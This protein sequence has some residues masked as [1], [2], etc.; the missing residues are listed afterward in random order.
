[1]YPLHKT[2]G[3]L[4]LRS[5]K[6][7]LG[8]RL[9]V[10]AFLLSSIALP[11]QGGGNIVDPIRFQAKEFRFIGTLRGGRASAVT[12]VLGEP[13]RYFMG[14]S[15]GGVWETKDAGTTWS[16]VSDGFFAAS[17]IGAIA[18]APSDASIIYVGTG[19]SCIRG[20]VQTGVG[21]YKSSDGGTT[22]SH[23]GLPDSRHIARVRIHPENPDIVYA[24]VLGNVFGPSEDRG[25]YRSTDGGKNWTRSLFV[26]NRAG[27]VDLAMDPGDPDT[28]YAA[29]YQVSRSPWSLISGGEDSGLYKSVDGGEN[30]KELTNG[31]PQGIKG[32][33]G[34]SVSPVDSNK[35]YVN[36][37]A[38]G[39][40]GLY[41][42]DSA[43]ETFEYV[44]DDGRLITRPFYYTHV[45]ASPHGRESVYVLNLD[46]LKSEDGGETYEVINKEIH[47]DFHDLWINPTD[48]DIMITGTDGGAAITLNGGISWSSQL[49]QPTG[50]IYRM[51]TDNRYPYRVYGT[52]QDDWTVSVPSMS[53]GKRVVEDVFS[54]G[55]GEHGHI[56]VHPENPDIVYAGNYEGIITRYDHGTG[57]MRNIE[58][59]P[60]LAEGVPAIELRYRFQMNAPIRI[61][62]HGP[63]VVYQVSQ[64]VHR[65]LDEGQSWEVISPDLTRNDESKQGFSGGPITRDH[66]GVETY[67]TIFAFEESYQHAGVF[68]V[69]TDDGLIHLSRDN[70]ATWENITPPDMPEWGTVNMI[71]LSANNPG[72]AFVPV[73]RYRLDDFTPYV[74]RTDDY[75]RNWVRLPLR[76]IPGTHFARVVREDPV[77]KGLMYLGTEFGLYISYDDGENW[78]NFQLNLPVVQIADMAIK[79]DDLVVATHGRGFWILDDL[80][81]VRLADLDSLDS[82]PFLFPSKDPFR[83]IEMIDGRNP[84]MGPTEFGRKD[85]S[86][87]TG[88]SVF[89]HLPNRPDDEVTIE[90]LEIDGSVIHQYSSSTNDL[91]V[92][93]GQNK[94]FWDLRYP[95]AVLFGDKLF[96]GGN[97]GPQ[98]VPGGYRMIMTVGDCSQTSDFTVRPY[99]RIVSSLDSL[100]QQFDLA[101]EIRD[102]ISRLN[103]DVAQ[104]AA[105]RQQLGEISGLVRQR[106]PQDSLAAQIEALDSEFREV[107]LSLVQDDVTNP[108]EATLLMPSLEGQLIQVLNIVLSSEHRPTDGA[109]QR[110]EDL[111]MELDGY[112]DRLTAFTDDRVP[113]LNRL[114][115]E[116]NLPVQIRLR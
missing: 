2:L 64:F 30:W 108:L 67:N 96:R 16:N 72:R 87:L 8:K 94:L 78:Q 61:S 62:R 83:R 7:K 4:P 110:F 35:V 47:Y 13:F 27:A 10:L 85:W 69:G 45:F 91:P 101:I 65:T 49:N 51:T 31:L 12:G 71:E 102:A 39:E 105:V 63:H 114:L 54:V 29:I 76:G 68:W 21:L 79:A 90:I 5:H 88:L 81:Q 58:A 23:S 33:I 28:L 32:R 95:P 77:R 6:Q 106:N 20:D 73:H 17:S 15:G 24:A 50:E 80:S 42:S 103:E 43:G 22:W 74:F 59:Y 18:V 38:L 60:Q 113:R 48:P 3:N 57:D 75:G 89:Y 82:E 11:N 86:D 44:S 104:I 19:E 115:A 100:Q 53:T 14:T 111:Q 98:A 70:G 66:T 46:L 34:V 1:M 56:A 37:E 107:E 41:R 112:R 116:E 25:V 26:S 93:R 40:G 84:L 55:G 109:I 92:D 9:C 99:P 52:Q 97:Y 36:I